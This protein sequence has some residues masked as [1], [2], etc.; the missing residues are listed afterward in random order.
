MTP[1]EKARKLIEKF[2]E[3]D[4]DWIATGNNYCIKQYALVCVDEILDIQQFCNNK[5]SD[6]VKFW[7]E[8]KIEIKQF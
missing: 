4:Y 1:K 7:N 5:N 8:V 2:K 3:H 6:V